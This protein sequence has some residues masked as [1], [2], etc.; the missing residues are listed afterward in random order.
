MK[1][2]LTVNVEKS[3]YMAITN[4]SQDLILEDIE[5]FKH[6]NAYKYLGVIIIKDGKH[7]SKIQKK[8]NIGKSSNFFFKWNSLG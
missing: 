2:V 8:D 4:T 6:C 1:W 3:N 5:I 7:D